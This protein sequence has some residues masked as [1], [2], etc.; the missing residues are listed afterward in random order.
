MKL[1]IKLREFIIKVQA[2]LNILGE[3]VKYRRKIKKELNI[4]P[5]P[6]L[7]KEQIKIM[8]VFYAGYGFKN[9]KSYWH[10]YYSGF[11]LGFSPKIIPQD[12]Y[13]A[14]IEGALNDRR[15]FYLQDK[16]LLDKLITGVKQAQILIKNINGFYSINDKII[17]LE[18]ALELLKNEKDIIIKP[19]IDTGGGRGIEKFSITNG[20]TTLNEKPLKSIFESYKKDFT[21]VRVVKQSSILDKLNPTSLNTIRIATYLIGNGEEVAILFSIIRIGKLGE[22]KDNVTTGG[23]YVVINENGMLSNVGYNNPKEKF[24][25]TESG[26]IFKDFEIPNYLKVVSTVKKL[27]QQLPYFRFISWDIAIDEENEPVVIEFNSFG[28][29][30]DFQTVCGPFFGDYTEEALQITMKKRGK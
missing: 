30:I 24:T 17:S 9:L 8:R 29:S 26:T 6:K 7:S 18:N 28:Q 13:F 16:N 21:I 14:H 15:F 27:H 5:V 19:T 1:F 4:F 3:T 25:Q 10:Q 11:G 22:F 23:I 20:I 2:R 12:M